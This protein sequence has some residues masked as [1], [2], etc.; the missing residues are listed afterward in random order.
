MIEA[1]VALGSNIG[2]RIKNLNKAIESLGRVPEIKINKI[3]NFYE[4]KPF[5]VPDQQQNYV[6]GCISVYTNLS[7]YALLGVCLGI[8][9]AMGRER[10]YRFCSRIIDLDL[11]FYGDEK[12]NSKEL[13]VPHPRIKERAF[14]MVP[15]SDIFECK[16]FYDY[17]FFDELN[18]M[19]TS[20]I[21]EL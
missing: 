1:V 4:T 5:G 6:N 10:K 11:I 12:Y 15:L 8:E 17:S 19:N 14:V 2:D 3:S 21:I 16:K 20:D 7:A 18:N 9:A 13:T